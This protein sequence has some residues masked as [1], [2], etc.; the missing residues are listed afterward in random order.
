MAGLFTSSIDE[1]FPAHNSK[2]QSK[3]GPR[4]C[5]SMARLYIKLSLSTRALLYFDRKDARYFG[6]KGYFSV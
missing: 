4:L 2:P 3:I 5:N 6:D 1:T